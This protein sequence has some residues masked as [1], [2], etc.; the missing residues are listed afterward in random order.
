MLCLSN[1]EVAGGVDRGAGKRR[2]VS[3]QQSSNDNFTHWER[4][5]QHL[6]SLSGSLEQQKITEWIKQEL[7]SQFWPLG[8]KAALWREEKKKRAHAVLLPLLRLKV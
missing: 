8:W 5:G 6:G 4:N 1:L 7:C 2:G 3:S